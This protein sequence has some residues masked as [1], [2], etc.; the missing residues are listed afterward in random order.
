MKIVFKERRID[1]TEND[2]KERDNIAI[3]SLNELK[4]SK[5]NF[6][7]TAAKTKDTYPDIEIGNLELDIK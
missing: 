5:Y 2:L 1:I 4:K 3:K 6:Y 7:V